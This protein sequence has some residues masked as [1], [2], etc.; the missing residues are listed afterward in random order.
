M[1][2]EM[3]AYCGTWCG[4]CEWREKT[5]CKGCKLQ[6]G[7]LFWGSCAVASCAIGKGL[8]HCGECALLP[9]ETLQ[10]AFDHPEHGDNGERLANLLNWKNDIES[11]LKVTRPSG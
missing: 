2:Q 7:R 5:G 8:Q 1:K 6:E 3:M 11:M 4:S 9:C 10:A